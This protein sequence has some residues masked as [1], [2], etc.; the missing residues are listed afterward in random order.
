VLSNYRYLIV[1]V[2]AFWLVFTLAIWL[3]NIRLILEIS[4]SPVYSVIDKISF[5]FS[6]YGSIFTNFTLFSATYTIFIGLFF[7][8]NISLL[9][10]YINK[11]RGVFKDVPTSS[12]SMSVGGLISGFLG[13]GC[14]ACGTFV[15]TSLLGVFG[16]AAILTML[17]L[18]GA[19]FGLFGLFILIVSVYVILGKINSPNTC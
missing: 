3:P 10:F 15:L 4:S 6:L 17:P 7:G 11:Q 2:V 18:G 5:I 19:E 8:V 16:S 1:S 13:I 14:A 9:L 12:V